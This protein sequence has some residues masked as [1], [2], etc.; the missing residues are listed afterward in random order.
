MA[1]RSESGEAMAQAHVENLSIGG[2]AGLKAAEQQA[3][4]DASS[5]RAAEQAAKSP[6]RTSPT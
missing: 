1:T 5:Q 6:P 3:E 2:Y 4:A